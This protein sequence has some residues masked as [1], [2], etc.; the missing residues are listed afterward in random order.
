MKKERLKYL[1]DLILQMNP[2]KDKQTVRVVLLIEEI[3]KF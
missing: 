1:K 3:K 2:M